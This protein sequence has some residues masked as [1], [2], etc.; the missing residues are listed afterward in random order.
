MLPSLAKSGGTAAADKLP[1]DELTD[2]SVRFE[3]A[4][5]F[6]VLA[7]NNKDAQ[8]IA[9]HANISHIRHC[10]SLGVKPLPHF[11][12]LMAGGPS[13]LVLMTQTNY[14]G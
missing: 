9:L 7:I 11:E 5:L 8:K 12:I 3:S 2:F 10:A 1:C 13:Q 4:W 14:R 6:E